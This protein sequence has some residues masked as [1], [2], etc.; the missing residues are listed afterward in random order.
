MVYCSK[1]G[2]KNDDG[3]S[4]CSQ[5]GATLEAA[6]ENHL[7]RRAKEWGE[8]L[9]RRVEKW[10]EQFGKRA[11]EECFGLPHGGAIVGLIFGI[12]LIIVAISWIPGLIPP[13]VREVA[14]PLFWP[15][16][17]IVVGILMVAG[18]LYQYSRR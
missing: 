1:C 14:D 15:V 5:C 9:E 16:I 7:E 6:R 18:V 12:I 10:G 13:E 3:D 11:E 8:D 2:A 17:I 4:H